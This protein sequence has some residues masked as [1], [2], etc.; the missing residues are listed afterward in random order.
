VSGDRLIEALTQRNGF[1]RKPRLPDKPRIADESVEWPATFDVHNVLTK[2]A[3]STNNDFCLLSPTLKH[4]YLE[5]LTLSALFKL[6]GA[7]RPRVLV[8]TPD[9]SVRQRYR[10]LSPRFSR[11][12]SKEEFPLATVKQDGTLSQKTSSRPDASYPPRALFSRHLHYLP[13]SEIASEVG[14]VIYDGAVNYRPNRWDEFKQWCEVNDIP[15]VVYCLRDPLAPEYQEV[16]DKTGVW[17]WPPAL[18][19]GVTEPPEQTAADGGTSRYVRVRNQLDNKVAGIDREIHTVT[20]G[21]LAEQFGKVWTR[22]EELQDV[23]SRLGSQALDQAIHELKRA[24]N[25]FSNTISSVGFTEQTYSEQWETLAP[26]NW[27]DRLDHQR[28][29][30]MKDD[31]GAQAGGVFRS[32]CLELEAAY[33]EWK[34]AEVGETKQGHLYRL[35][36]GALERDEAV[37]VVVPREADREAVNLDLQQRGGDLYQALGEEIRIVTP[38][39]LAE[40]RT[41]DR[42]ILAGPPGWR[43]RWVLR[44]PHAP[45]VTVLTY[46]HQLSLLNYQFDVL[47]DA[48]RETTD[49]T[50]YRKAVEAAAGEV[51]S[52]ASVVDQLDIERPDIDLSGESEIAE[53]YEVVDAH[54]PTSVDDIIDQMSG[55]D[56]FAAGADSIGGSQSSRES[57]PTECLRLC[58][59]DGR[60]M[61]VRPGHGLHAIDGEAGGVTKRDAR[62]VT[63]GNTL[64]RIRQTDNLRQQLYD[65]IKQGGDMRLIMKANLWK[66]KLEQAIEERD[67]TLDDFIERVEA[68]GADCGRDAYRGW[69]N[70][71]V[72]YTRA[73]ENM[74]HI[75]DAYDLAVVKDELEEIWGAAHEIKRT[76]MKLLRELRK[77]AYQAAA[78]EETDEVVLSEEHD[79]RLSDIDTIDSSG[80]NLVERL[81]VVDVV[82]DTVGSHRLGNIQHGED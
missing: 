40:A 11:P 32:A 34:D 4:E 18:I 19:E 36:Y 48:L 9:S 69:Y 14:C 55:S 70:R 23:Q 54:E 29:R 79:I 10:E 56:D 81:T 73:Y 30:L 64:V 76:Y 12:W 77:R 41:C 46:E 27:F 21:P 49:Q 47:N 20:D 25:D 42:V 61:P 33:N 74:E 65:L 82:E 16:S 17:A 80:N 2:G 15:T 57:T 26:S 1:S 38:D 3:I 39:T 7:S 51:E 35:L 37:T 24:L 63:P 75:A 58:F 31:T 22:I 8:L 71:D 43:D 78:G 59:E 72:D 28:E 68:E 62:H 45:S 53:G 44:T 52:T 60:W 6:R 67:D 13:N 50:R 5:L 66:I